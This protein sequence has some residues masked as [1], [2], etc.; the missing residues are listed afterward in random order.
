MRVHNEHATPLCGHH[1]Q[2]V[3][4]GGILATQAAC[5]CRYALGTSLRLRSGFNTC[6]GCAGATREDQT[7]GPKHG[8]TKT[9]KRIQFH[10]DVGT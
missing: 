3:R 8:Q 4:S 6:C 1:D 9:R 10:G 5:P 2:V 7:C